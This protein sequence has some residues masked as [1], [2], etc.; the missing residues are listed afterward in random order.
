MNEYA[1]FGLR[2]AIDVVAVVAL[3]YGIHARTS[4]R[5]DVAAALVAL[6]IG[7][8]VVLTAL[9]AMPNAGT[10]GL[11]VGFGLFAVLSII[12]LRSE[13]SSL[14]EVAYFFT[15]LALGVVNGVDFGDF[16][17]MALLDVVLVGGMAVLELTRRSDGAERQVIV[18][19]EV[20]DS[21]AELVRH[22][23]RRL[24]VR[25]VELRV[26]EVDI[27]RE[28]TRVEAL[29]VEDRAAAADSGANGHTATV[30]SLVGPPRA[31]AAR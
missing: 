3:A 22:L 16:G 13:A 12:R 1:N 17:L 23:S 21:R 26:L 8:L 2:L 27:V 15:A 24:G 14:T 4:R 9:M 11:T 31:G 20:F 29:V 10:G 5:R 6:N 30:A 18:A 25:V 7:L 19:D 28:T